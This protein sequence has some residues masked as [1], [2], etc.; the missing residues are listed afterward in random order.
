MGDEYLK[1]VTAEL[2]HR[3]CSYFLE[4]QLIS[5]LPPDV[6]SL[7]TGVLQFRGTSQQDYRKL[8]E[9]YAEFRGVPFSQVAAQGRGMAYGA[10]RRATDPALV[11]RAQPLILRPSASWAGGETLSV[12]AG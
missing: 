1:E 2:R 9:L 10:F 4:A 5:S 3:P 8:Q 6:V 12:A 7:A 11:A